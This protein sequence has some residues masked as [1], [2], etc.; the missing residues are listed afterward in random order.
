MP[1][2]QITILDRFGTPVASL[3]GISVD[4]PAAGVRDVTYTPTGAATSTIPTLQFTVPLVVTRNDALLPGNQVNLAVEGVPGI[5]AQAIIGV[6]SQTISRDGLFATF[7]CEDVMGELRHVTTSGGFTSRP[8]EH[9][10]DVLQRLLNRQTETQWTAVMDATAPT[11]GTFSAYGLSVMQAVGKFCS[12]RFC[13]Y[14]RGPG[15]SI[16]V[17]RFGTMSSGL[18]LSRSTHDAD[19]QYLEDDQRIITELQ[20]EQDA[21][22]VNLIIPTASGDGATQITLQ[23]CYGRSN[24]VQYDGRY[25]VMQ[26]LRED[27]VLPAGASA[28]PAEMYDYYIQ[29]NASINQFRVSEDVY[30]RTDITPIA[31]TPAD[32]ATASESL[33]GA[34]VAYLLDHKDI[35]Q[36]LTV[37]TEG[38][39]DL[40]DIGGKTVFVDYQEL[41]DDG[42]VV[43]NIKG[44]YQVL[45]AEVQNADSAPT[46]RWTLSNNGRRADSDTALFTGALEAIDYL[47]S[48][49]S[50]FPQ[51]YTKV[52][53]ND[54]DANHPVRLRVYGNKGVVRVREALCRVQLLPARST[55]QPLSHHHTVTLTDHTHGFTVPNHSHGFPLP[56]HQ[57]TY[58]VPDHTHT[59]QLGDHSHGVSGGSHN[60][61]ISKGSHSHKIIGTKPFIDLKGKGAVVTAAVGK[62]G[63]TVVTD[64][65]ATDQ[66]GDHTHG[67][68]AAA[69]WT[70]DPSNTQYDGFSVGSGSA[71]GTTG[72]P[73]AG[74]Y[75]A[76]TGT[77][78]GVTGVTGGTNTDGGSNQTSGGGGGTVA[79][80]DENVGMQYGMWTSDFL[81]T[82][83]YVVIDGVQVT[84]GNNADFVVDVAPWISDQNDHTI[85]VRAFTFGRVA[86]DLSIRRD[87]TTLVSAYMR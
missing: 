84:G 72:S 50:I 71:G 51:E 38:H 55:A 85:E 70:Q 19:Q 11:F 76:L 27:A 47:T 33:Y 15:R 34:A 75:T 28:Y 82:T 63:E 31:S 44:D 57:H 64:I 67:E 17:G 12:E 54:L 18:R 69:V 65:K 39:G 25:P 58:G 10:G 81:P 23:A 14:K 2:V 49:P 26:R 74:L 80:S 36:T 24:F 87:V 62:N 86:V 45:Q 59:F 3:N 40:R 20:V 46:V 42:D 4:G 68:E 35:N 21:N 30:N 8:T 48:V 77:S 79:T 52:V 5:V 56:T 22:V 66:T 6:K 83:V 13:S 7:E 60:H 9:G 29:D 1:E 32:L 73:T 61:T 16:V 37:T 43:L 53:E 78:N 41:N